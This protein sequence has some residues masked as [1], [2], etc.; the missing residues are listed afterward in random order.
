[1]GEKAFEKARERGR[2][3]RFDQAIAYALLEG[4]AT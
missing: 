2:E 1:M 3:M 4:E